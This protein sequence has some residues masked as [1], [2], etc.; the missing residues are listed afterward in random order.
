M[1]V[2]G[3]HHTGC[4]KHKPCAVCGTKFK[5]KSGIHKFCSEKCKGKHKYLTGEITTESQ[6]KY[7][8]GNWQRYFS[9][10]VNRS[11]G[12]AELTVEE[13]LEVLEN[14]DYKCALSGVE[15]TCKLEKG[16]VFKTNASIDRIEAGGPYIK[17]NIQLVCRAL[18]SWRGD[19]PVEEFIW[20]CKRVA[21]KSRETGEE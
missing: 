9:R 20:W 6:Y 13:L 8:S 17:E 5:P 3:W 11:R 14:Q 21:D 12:R 18:N 4:F 19:T 7:I 16:T 15:L 10:L 2:G 1:S